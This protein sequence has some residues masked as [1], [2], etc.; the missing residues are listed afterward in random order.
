[1]TG[2][3]CKRVHAARFARER[4]HGGLTPKLDTDAVPKRPTYKQDW[5]AYN[6]AQ[7]VERHRLQVLL[8]DLCAG[9]EKPPRAATGR[10]PVPLA[11]RV[12]ASVYK[13]YSLLSSR[14]FARDLADAHAN[15]FLSRPLHPNRVNCFLESED[16]T[17]ALHGL[18]TRCSLPLRAVETEFAVDSTGF[19][20]SR[21]VR[22]YDEK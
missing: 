22:W 3:T 11:D 5:P 14:R 16:L 1:L 17:P 2:K 6:V 20:T 19:S 21:F 10:P 18:I 7:H 13:V 9:V 8:A 12:F 15:G 4:D